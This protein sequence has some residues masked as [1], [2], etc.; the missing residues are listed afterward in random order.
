MNFFQG[1]SG[2]PL[3]T[4]SKIPVLVG[5]VSMAKTDCGVNNPAPS[6]YTSVGYFRAW[7]NQAVKKLIYGGFR[8]P[9]LMKSSSSKKFNSILKEFQKHCLL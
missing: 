5:I 1:D 3:F 9:T 2:G 8:H 4:I 7:I 6:L